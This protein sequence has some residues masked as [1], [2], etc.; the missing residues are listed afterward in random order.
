MGQKKTPKKLTIRCSHPGCDFTVLKTRYKKNGQARKTGG[1][2]CVMHNHWMSKHE[3]AYLEILNFSNREPEDIENETVDGLVCP[4]E[5]N[6]MDAVKPAP[7]PWDVDRY[8]TWEM[9][10]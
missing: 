3:Q 2:W 8:G 10:W 4:Q 1:S 7:I 9:R 5:E 6:R